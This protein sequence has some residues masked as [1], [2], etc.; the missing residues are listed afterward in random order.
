MCLGVPGRIVSVTDD[1]PLLRMGTVDFD[2][3][4]RAVC[5]AY[6]P[7]ATVGDYVIVHVGFAITRIDAQEAATTLAVIRAASLAPDPAAEDA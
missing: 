3:V 6:V 2:G 5:L 4:R 7:D 1:D